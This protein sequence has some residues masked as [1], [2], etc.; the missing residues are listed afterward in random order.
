M[1]IV[2]VAG[3]AVRRDCS[4]TSIVNWQILCRGIFI[5]DYI[6]WKLDKCTGDS[7]GMRGQGT[8]VS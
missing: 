8:V 3:N 7:S 4:V 2:P 6:L 5:I 1:K